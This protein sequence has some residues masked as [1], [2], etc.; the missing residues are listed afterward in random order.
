MK[1]ASLVSYKII[2]AISGGEK[3]IYYFLQYFGKYASITC[4]TVSENEATEKEHFIATPV[5]GSSKSKFRYINIFLFFKLRRLLTRSGIKALII[6]HPYYGWLGFLLK[7]FAG[8]RLIVHSHNIENERFRTMS[9]WWW[10]ILYYYERF[11]HRAADMNFFITEEDRE[12]AI[13]K[14]N[15]NPQN[16]IVITY[17]IENEKAV[18]LQEKFIAKEHLCNE[19]NLTTDT[20][21]ILF[22]GT[23][24]Y[25]PN[26]E[27]L[28]MILS[29]IN[30]ILKKQI[31]LPYKIIV[32]G[33]RLPEE[34]N[35]LKKYQPDNIIYKGFVEDIGFY[36][37]AADIFINPIIE[38]GGI[39]TKLVE[40]LAANTPAVS[41]FTGAYGIPLSVT[42]NHL[43]IVEDRNYERFADA[44]A[45]TALQK[46]DNIDESFFDHF[47]WGNIAKKAV[48]EINNLK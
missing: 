43:K 4:Y 21:L 35:E 42:G 7:H 24:D 36:F 17:G 13:R 46:K 34:Y 6:E 29:E 5:L 32:C 19:L 10:K 25:P 9:K 45:A 3:G 15:I 2:P 16:C 27:G 22:N 18:P 14:F 38:G 31:A 40:A 23:L 1:V 28:D 20:V 44:I 39:K 41:F 26:R 30:P 11:T 48:G 12:Y 37:K 47:Y 33:L 8:I